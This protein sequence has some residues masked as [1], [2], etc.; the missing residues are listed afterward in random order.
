MQ[1]T[2]RRPQ[3]KK[4]VAL[5]SGPRIPHGRS[6]SGSP[7]R[8]CATSLVPRRLRNGDAVRASSDRRTEPEGRKARDPVFGVEDDLADRHAAREIWIAFVARRMHTDHDDGSGGGRG[9]SQAARN[10]RQALA[11][12]VDRTESGSGPSVR[13]I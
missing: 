7:P 4:Y 12:F 5:A 3:V 10:H 1:Y 6:R 8:P 13:G 9:S 2:A 11:G